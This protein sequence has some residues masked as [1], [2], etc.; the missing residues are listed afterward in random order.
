MEQASTYC[1][2]EGDFHEYGE[3][4]PDKVQ[5]KRSDLDRV[6]TMMD[7][8]ASMKHVATEEFSAFVKFFRGFQ[9]YQT[10]TTSKRNFKSQVMVITGDPGTFKSYSLSKLRARYHVVRP[11][12]KG[13]GCW[14]D[15]Y[16]PGTHCTVIYDDFTGGWMPFN[17]LLEL[18]DRYA[19]QVQSKGGTLQFRPIVIGFTSNYIASQWY[20]AME[21]SAL[22]RR[23]DEH[24]THHRVEAG[25]DNLGL[26]VG[27]VG[28]RCLK[29]DITHHPLYD[30][31]YTCGDGETWRIDDETQKSLVGADMNSETGDEFWKVMYKVQD[32]PD[33]EY[34]PELSDDMSHVSISDDSE[35]SDDISE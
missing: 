16:E 18:T 17:N 14:Y 30:Y 7:E 5:G 23:I 34:E 19:C 25:D 27:D 13:A 29:G 22:E 35:D 28:V 21:Y 2:K 12:A 33:E 9:R 20:P 15:G 24:Y 31:M 26:V 6:K 11:T 10:L 8:G 32:L 3:L 4:P 1:K